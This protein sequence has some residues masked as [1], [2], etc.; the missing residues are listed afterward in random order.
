VANDIASAVVASGFCGLAQ[1]QGILLCGV[2][3]SKFSGKGGG[4][5]LSCANFGY[6][7]FY[8][9]TGGKGTV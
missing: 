8:A 5:G 9:P 3:F 4:G 6:Y 7:R 2:L 1:R